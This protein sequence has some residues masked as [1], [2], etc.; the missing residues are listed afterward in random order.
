VDD[1]GPGIDPQIID[2]IFEPFF[3]TKPPGEGTGLGLA[4]VRSILEEH[5]GE[6][7]AHNREDGG[8]RFSIRLPAPVMAPA[9]G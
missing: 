5:G 4:V 2:R 3:T 7:S 8:A 1:T 9:H 6:V